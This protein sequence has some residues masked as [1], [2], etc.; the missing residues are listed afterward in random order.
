MWAEDELQPELGGAL[1]LEASAQT[2]TPIRE[3]PFG[4]ERV[5]NA[6]D[7]HSTSN[8]RERKCRESE[9]KW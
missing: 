2:L 8:E 7:Q 6:G 3:K 9:V 5:Q 4:S 1:N